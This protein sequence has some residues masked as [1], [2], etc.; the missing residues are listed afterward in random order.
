MP[1]H[2]PRLLAAAA[3]L[4]ALAV[5]AP[6]ASASSACDYLGDPTAALTGVSAPEGARGAPAQHEP[7]LDNSNVEINGTAPK[8]PKTFRATVPVYFH[9]ITDGAKGAVSD[10]QIADQVTV[11][12]RTFSGALGGANAGFRFTLAG[13]DRTNDAT[14]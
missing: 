4:A 11:L 14:W 3:A 1:N 8:V 13:V 10:K 2:R 7:G 12:N 9:V 6:A 5:T